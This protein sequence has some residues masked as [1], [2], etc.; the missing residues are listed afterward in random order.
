MPIKLEIRM[1]DV[2]NRLT[3]IK[4]VNKRWCR[5]YIECKCE[6]WSIKEIDLQYVVSKR[7]SSCGCLQKEKVREAVTKH[8]LSGTR[9]YRIWINL[10]DRCRN[11]RN[12]RYKNYWWRWIKCEWNSFE[13]FYKDMKEWY[14]DILSIDR[15]NND[16]DYCKENCKWATSRE[17]ARN[18]RST[19]H[20]TYNNKTQCLKDWCSELWVNYSSIITRI[21][22]HWW[23][24]EKALF[25][26]IKS[27]NN[28]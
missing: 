16:G 20:Y 19:I 3:I 28:L 12:D 5:R 23:S 1:W 4:E 27:R 18:T 7:I 24:I 13:E 8:W 6:C 15:I 10:R 25:T 14:S 21:R 26:P 22:T 2:Y 17:Q 9:I 11:K